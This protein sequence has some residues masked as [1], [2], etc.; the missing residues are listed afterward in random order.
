MSHTG[1]A[2]RPHAAP[3]NAAGVS[4]PVIVVGLDGSPTRWDAFAWAAGEATR[5]NGTL[6]AVYALGRTLQGADGHGLDV[7]QPPH[8]GSSAARVLMR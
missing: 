6:T 3:E 7:A 4:H 5:G 1:S 2:T 8:K